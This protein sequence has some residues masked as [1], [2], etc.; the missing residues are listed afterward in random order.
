MQKAEKTLAAITAAL[1]ADGC[2]QFRQNLRTLLPKME[3]AYRGQEDPFRNHLGASGIGRDCDRELQLKWRWA[4]K[5]KFPERVLRLFNRGHLEEARFLAML[6][7]VP[8]INLWYE[9][10]DGGQFKWQDYAG[11]YGSALDGI[12]TGIPD[13]PN[14]E[15]AYTEF[16][17]SN[18]SGFKKLVKSGVQAEKYE[19]YVQMQQC[20][21][22][23]KLNW[24]LYMAVCKETD[25][26]HAEVI[27]YDSQIA[28]RYSQ[29]AGRIIYA[30]DALPRLNNS[31]T[32]FKCKWC[33]ERNVCHGKSIP[34]INCRTCAHWS[35]T[36]DG[37]YSCEKNGS[38]VGQKRTAM[39]GCD[40][41]IF[42][43]TLLPGYSFLGGNFEENYTELQTRTGVNFKQGPGHVT[44]EQLRAGY[45]EG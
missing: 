33:D 27:K 12:A 39:L 42:D 9:T 31:P 25:E 29:R 44:S 6:L 11:H 4:S 38:A 15:A 34:E 41:H 30:T 16:K 21:K 20:M 17:T 19:H 1:D 10:E 8:G 13:I 23:Y 28:E 24:S 7:C 18:T 35:P 22:Y 26:L 14:G 43:P 40:Q 36:Q 37:G 2:G 45:I 5:T 3:D 32:F